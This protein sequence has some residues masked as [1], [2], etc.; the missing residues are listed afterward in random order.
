MVSAITIFFV[1]VFTHLFGVGQVDW[2]LAR[3]F[4]ISIVSPAFAIC[5]VLGILAMIYAMI[6]VQARRWHLPI[7]VGMAAYLAWANNDPL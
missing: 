1:T 6:A 4:G 5:T 3:W 7:V 2:W